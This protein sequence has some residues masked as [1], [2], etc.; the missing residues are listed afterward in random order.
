MGKFKNWRVVS[1]IDAE[2]NLMKKQQQYDAVLTVNDDD[3]IYCERSSLLEEVDQQEHR[4]FMMMVGGFFIPFIALGNIYLH[5]R[6]NNSE[7]R[8]YVR[9]SGI[10]IAAWMI[11]ITFIILRFTL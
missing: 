10:S 11:F 3:D 8:R 9:A 6:S 2:R 7:I 4:A 5:S 1:T